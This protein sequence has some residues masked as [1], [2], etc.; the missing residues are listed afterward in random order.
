MRIIFEPIP[1]LSEQDRNIV[2]IS[3]ERNNIEI[4]K[5]ICGLCNIWAIEDRSSDWLV[6]ARDTLNRCEALFD[7]IHKAYKNGEKLFDVREWEENI[8][9]KIFEAEMVKEYEEACE[10]EMRDYELRNEE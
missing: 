4:S 8:Q 10:R 7:A 9:M 3:L 2:S 6:V 1:M 5:E